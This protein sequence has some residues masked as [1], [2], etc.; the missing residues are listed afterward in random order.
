[1]G[2]C[3]PGTSPEDLL[4]ALEI[5]QT[6]LRPHFPKL[7]ACDSG[8]PMGTPPEN[9]NERIKAPWGGHFELAALDTE[10]WPEDVQ[11]MADCIG[12]IP[13]IALCERFSGCQVYF[14]RYE[15]LLRSARDAEIR[16]LF[17]GSNTKQLS[18]KF[19]MT[20]R[21]IHFILNG[22]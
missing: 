9:D 8:R 1:M 12:L 7:L 16:R 13:A 22:K 4:K 20:S 15:S 5:L 10:D 3:G 14:P 6:F 11:S 17:D 18:R 19:D 2:Q 21:A